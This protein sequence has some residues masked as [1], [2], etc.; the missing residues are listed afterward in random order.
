MCLPRT[1]W[2]H[3]KKEIYV[4]LEHNGYTLRKNLYVCL[5]HNG[6]ILRKK[7]CICLEHNGYILRKKFICLPRTQWIHFKKKI[8]MF[9]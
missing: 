7:L 8:Y 9:A 5:E 4:C 2:I 1:Q 3:F 6:Y